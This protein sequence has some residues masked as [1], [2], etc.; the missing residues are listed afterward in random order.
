MYACVQA[1]AAIFF[2]AI[3]T[4]PSDGAAEYTKGSQPPGSLGVTI[5]ILLTLTRELYNVMVSVS[6]AA[7]FVVSEVIFPAIVLTVT[8]PDITDPTVPD[9]VSKPETLL[10]PNEIPF[11]AES[12]IVVDE[13]NCTVPVDDMDS[14]DNPLKSNVESEMTP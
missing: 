10:S 12:V 6:E 7:K 1:D 14:D 13:V 8:S 11:V 3:A 4:C 5:T 9:P 2:T